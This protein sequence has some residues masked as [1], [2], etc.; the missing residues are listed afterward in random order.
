MNKKTKSTIVLTSMAA[1]MASTLLIS[2]ATYALFTSESKTNIAVTSGKVEVVATVKDFVT[3]SGTDLVGDTTLDESKIVKTNPQGTFNNG[4]TAKY[5]DTTGSVIL[6]NITP[7]DRVSFTISV[8]NN[9]NVTVKYRTKI[10]KIEDD[11]LFDSLSVKINGSKYD[12]TTK[13]TA[14]SNLLANT[15]PDDIYVVIDLPSDVGNIYQNKTCKIANVVEAIQANAHLEDSIPVND[16]ETLASTIEA[17]KPVSL[18]SDITLS[19]PLAITKNTTIY[20]NGKTLSS[21]TT[22]NRAITLNDS[23]NVTLT[24]VDVNIDAKSIERGLSIFDNKNLKLVLDNSSIIA[25]HY[26]FNIGGTNEGLELVIKNNSKIIGYSAFNV[27]SAGIKVVAENSSFIGLNKWNGSSDDFA[28]IVLNNHATDGS[29]NNC[30][31]SFTNCDIY[32]YENGIAKERLLRVDSA[33]STL[34]F[35]GC[36]FYHGTNYGLNNESHL[37]VSLTNSDGSINTT[38]AS[39]SDTTT[40]NIK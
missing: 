23:K 12:G 21:T 39:I 8:K 40:I 28:T 29:A 13:F 35:E 1:I 34:S 36:G 9:S 17:G 10:S 6:S 15:N 11:G 22:N 3:Y 26:L 2:G 18:N 32:A 20:G 31:F 37:K 24:L 19:S 25:D 7:G 30:N 4:G 33:Y 38:Y 14:Y 27:F 16:S 5:D